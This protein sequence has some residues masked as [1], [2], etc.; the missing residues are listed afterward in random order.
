MALAFTYDCIKY[1]DIE[2]AG[3]VTFGQPLVVDARLRR[4]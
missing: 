3:V 1:A 2:P 4:T